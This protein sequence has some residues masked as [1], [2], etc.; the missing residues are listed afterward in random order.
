MCSRGP[1]LHVAQTTECMLQ[2]H[3]VYKTHN[4]WVNSAAYDITC[5][6][7]IPRRADCILCVL[8][9]QKHALHQNQVRRLTCV[10]QSSRGHFQFSAEV[11]TAI[12]IGHKLLSQVCHYHMYLPSRPRP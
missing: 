7:F 2:Q 6:G 5:I 11:G 1:I 4:H 12:D 3:Q 10:M 8:L 9:D